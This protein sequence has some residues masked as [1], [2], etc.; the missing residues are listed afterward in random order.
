MSCEQIRTGR[1]LL[2]S[3]N[4]DI[5]CETSPLS[6]T[7]DP[8]SWKPIGLVQSTNI[9]TTVRE[10]TSNTD[11]STITDTAALGLDV[12][13]SVSVNDA[14]VDSVGVSNQEDLREYIEDCTLTVDNLKTPKLWV[15]TKDT[16][17]N[18]YKYY[19]M[20][21]GSTETSSE[22]EGLRSGSFSF[23]MVPTYKDS[24]PSL[25]RETYTP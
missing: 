9:T 2:V 15:R 17:A 10:V 19:Y 13:F 4:R 11:S 18:K 21:A 8:A 22:N 5:D 25:Q 6:N 14:P 3:F 20:M 12:E 16:A 1:T 7:T 24:N 23:K